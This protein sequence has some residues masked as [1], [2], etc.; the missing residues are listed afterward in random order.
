[1]NELENSFQHMLNNIIQA[2]PNVI[3][4]LLLLLLAWVVAIIAKNIVQKLFV[5][6]G[7]HKALSRTSL[8]K[9]D[10]HGKS[11]LENVGKIV[12][13]LVF[14]LFLPAIL[15]ALSMDS[16]SE[17]I[18]NMMNKLLG[19]IPNLIAAALIL[20]IGIFLAKVIKDLF[21]KFFQSLNLDRWFNKVHPNNAGGIQAQAT[22]SS[23]L[24]NIIYILILI[25]IITIALEA[26]N[27]QT[28]SEPIQAVLNDVL[29][30]IPNIFVAIILVIVGYYL[31]KLLG[32]LLTNLLH[33]TGI[34]NI[35][36]SLGINKNGTK[37]TLD[38]A[39]LLGTIVQVLIIL[40]FTVEALNVLQ[41]EVLNTIGDA[42]LIYLPFLI[43]ALVILG[44]GL[45][46]ANLLEN[47]IKTYT[48]SPFSAAV[49]KCVI[50]VFAVFMTLDQLQFAKSIVNI[51]FL[52]ILGG[53]MVAFAISFGIGGREFAKNQLA[54]LE[55]KMN[56][57]KFDQ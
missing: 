54:K 37:P 25:P 40:F 34:N 2:I 7:V 26:L 23:V 30:M 51:A 16:V 24:G 27:I 5:K 1:M 55:R 29:T 13:F 48:N 57:D 4:A 21:V 14:I 12:Y 17:P 28:I 11:I 35:Y 44:A 56:K 49:V 47:W 36:Q 32:N 45:I 38:L 22:L 15:D 42:L 3:A 43:S 41:L 10:V 46:L 19:F 52:L 18:S 9:D 39:K 33:G 8:V 31:A 20:I 53:L 50:I 6:I